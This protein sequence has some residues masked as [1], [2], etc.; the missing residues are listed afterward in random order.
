MNSINSTNSCRFSRF[1]GNSFRHSL[2][3]TLRRK[4]A[5]GQF[6]PD[7]PPF[8]R[9]LW[10]SLPFPSDDLV[11]RLVDLVLHFR[12]PVLFGQ[13]SPERLGVPVRVQAAQRCGLA[14]SKNVTT[15]TMTGST[16]HV[17]MIMVP[18]FLTGIRS[19]ASLRALVRKRQSKGDPHRI[20]RLNRLTA[21][22]SSPVRLH[23][24]DLCYP[25][26]AT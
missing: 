13:A 14:T 25:P 2:R 9:T 11:L 18:F 1:F 26:P 15:A 22:T 7:L 16:P 24:A 5:F 20:D 12:Q 3:D 4:V 17:C 19:N 23:P 21:W 8:M 10:M 6:L